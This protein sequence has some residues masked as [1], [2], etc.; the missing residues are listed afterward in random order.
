MT[1]AKSQKSPA[2]KD[3]PSPRTEDGWGETNHPQIHGATQDG[4]VASR[5]GGGLMRRLEPPRALGAT[6]SLQKPPVHLHRRCK[7][8]GEPRNTMR[9]RLCREV[10]H[11]PRWCTSHTLSMALS[12]HI[13]NGLKMAEL[14]KWP[15]RLVNHELQM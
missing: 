12:S 10:R 7:I 9:A 11:L 5:L 4:E 1:L 6:L 3:T 8:G 13:T 2:G 15:T 14:S